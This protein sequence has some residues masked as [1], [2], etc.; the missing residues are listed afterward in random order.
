MPDNKPSTVDEY[1]SGFPPEVRQILHAIREA[2]RQAVPD[3]EEAVK[4]GMPTYVLKGNLL[5][6]GAYKKH[7]G[8]YPVPQGDEV[9][10]ADVAPFRKERSTLQFPLHEPI[11]FELIA[12]TAK[13]RVAEMAPKV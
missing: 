1:I 3:A 5:S 4:Y 12:R 6:F 8:V 13:L 2:V 9:Y 10:Q 11:P 7:I